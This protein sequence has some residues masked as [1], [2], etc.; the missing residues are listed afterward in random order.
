MFR[1]DGLHVFYENKRGTAYENSKKGDVKI[2]LDKLGHI[3]YAFLY[4]PIAVFT[5]P[6]A[7]WAI[8]PDDKNDGL[9]YRKAFGRKSLEDDSYEEAVD[10]SAEEIAE[11]GW[12]V[13]VNRRLVDR[14]AE[15]RR[16]GEE[17]EDESLRIAFE[18]QANNLRSLSRWIMALASH[19]IRAYFSANASERFG[20]LMS[21]E[22]QF[23]LYWSNF[24]EKAEEITFDL[25]RVRI[26]KK[27]ARPG[28]NL[29]KSEK[30][31]EAA[32]TAMMQHITKLLLAK[33]KGK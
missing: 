11:L 8:N 18:V 5:K 28:V 21:D 6:K 3:R 19:G 12:A 14:V 29:S 23:E 25:L 4:D 30:D 33:S 22:A 24:V 20:D 7:F 16:L 9:L 10:Y 15:Y 31:W 17:Q 1:V 2:T 27:E 26:D 32:C 13:L